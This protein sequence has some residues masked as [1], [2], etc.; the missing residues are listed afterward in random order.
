VNERPVD[1][2]GRGTIGLSARM[3]RRPSW[4]EELGQLGLGK[5]PVCV[6]THVHQG[7]PAAAAGL[8]VGDW[9][10]RA[11]TTRLLDAEAIIDLVRHS[12]PGSTLSLTVRRAEDG[13]SET[14]DVTVGRLPEN[15]QRLRL[16]VDDA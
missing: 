14:V 9:L 6:V 10:L 2:T 7:G 1:L 15:E 5:R 8:Q 12:R 4:M 16:G 3:V 11:G 13:R